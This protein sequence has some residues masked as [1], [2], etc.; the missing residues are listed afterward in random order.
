MNQSGEQ[1]VTEGGD[2]EE[3]KGKSLDNQFVQDIQEYIQKLKD[4]IKD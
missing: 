2:I 3:W 1:Y 4:T